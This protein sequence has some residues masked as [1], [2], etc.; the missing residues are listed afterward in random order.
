MKKR[1]ASILMALIL[2]LTLLPTTTYAAE[3]GSSSVSLGTGGLCEHHTIHDE[4][5]GYTEGTEEVPCT[6]EHGA[7]CYTETINCIHIHTEDCYPVSDSSISDG[8]AMQAENAV[9]TEAAEPTECSHVCS[10]ESGCIV[11]ELQCPH[12]HSVRSDR[13]HG[14]E[15]GGCAGGS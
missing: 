11:Q 6:H 14:M 1:I 13:D 4:A 2:C 8:E 3:D 9:P 10:E 12:T 15:P 7:E 5:C